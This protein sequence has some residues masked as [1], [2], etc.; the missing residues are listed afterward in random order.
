MHA[1][2]L[3]DPLG[4]SKL[5]L[6]SK[7]IW[8]AHFSFPCSMQVKHT[9]GLKGTGELPQVLHQM[10]SDHRSLDV[11]DCF[12]IVVS[13]MVVVEVTSFCLAKIY[14]EYFS[15]SFSWWYDEEQ[16]TATSRAS[17]IERSLVYIKDR[18]NDYLSHSCVIY[19][20]DFEA[21]ETVVRSLQRCCNSCY[22]R[23]CLSGWLGNHS[24][25][26]CCRTNILRR[27]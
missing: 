19:L 23:E 21:D 16:E 13:L 8:L 15:D 17:R 6:M 3:S 5:I 20:S 22:H 27:S 4:T 26:P 11:H 12:L 10:I 24:S 2:H 9:A 7:A 14:P 1:V 18:P 25:C